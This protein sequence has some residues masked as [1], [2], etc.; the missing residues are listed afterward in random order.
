MGSGETL[1]PSNVLE[2][3]K[4]IIDKGWIGP[5][6]FKRHYLLNGLCPF[7]LKPFRLIAISPKNLCHFA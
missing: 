6:R 2:W 4:G 1:G 3:T 7:R 5:K